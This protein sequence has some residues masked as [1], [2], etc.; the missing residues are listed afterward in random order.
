MI[1]CLNCKNP[2]DE[3]NQFCG[4]CGAKLPNPKYCPNGHYHS[5]END[6][7]IKCGEKLVSKEEYEKI[8]QK[9]GSLLQQAREFMDKNDFYEA[10]KCF[11]K[12]LKIRP[13]DILSWNEKRR[14]FADLGKYEDAIECCDKLIEIDSKD[15]FAFL[16]K[17][18]YL[19]KLGKIEEAI[20]CFDKS[21]LID[22]NYHSPYIDKGE[23][24]LE[25]GKFDDVVYCFDKA[26]KIKNDD[27]LYWDIIISKLISLSKFEEAMDYCN[28]GLNYHPDDI[29]LNRNKAILLGLNNE[30]LKANEV[31]SKYN[32][33]GAR[34]F[35]SVARCFNFIGEFHKAKRFCNKSIDLDPQCCDYWLTMGEI[36]FNLEKYDESLKYFKK[37]FELSL[38]DRD[39][40]I[41]GLIKECQE[42]V[43]TNLFN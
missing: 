38:D 34:I 4:K 9:I 31:I 30:Y 40:L 22:S 5:Y 29:S 7:C 16:F 36:Y 20:E 19:N 18:N 39:E 24:L 26:L 27:P 41:N 35:Y 15:N 3:D 13:D 37:G 21:I 42:F 8:S 28:R 12:L 11:D 14:I 32:L 6:F 10:L 43:K 33:N 17:G 1:N 23:A 2:N 25:L